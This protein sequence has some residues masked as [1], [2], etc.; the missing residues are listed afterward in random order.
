MPR[1]PKDKPA[2]KDVQGLKYLRVLQPLLKSLHTVG[3]ARD[4]AGN[5]QL[6]FDQYCM[7]IL[8]SMF[9]PT[10][11]SLRGIQQASTLNKLQRK[12][13][14]PRAALGTLSE[15]PTLFD[16]EALKG[17]AEAIGQKIPQVAAVDQGNP[18]TELD[19]A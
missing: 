5:R 19:R 17:V 8:M 2:E 16:P 11:T 9:S 18:L 13:K 12:F 14:T 15:A 6:H 4:T 3:T 10:I 7:L 1:K